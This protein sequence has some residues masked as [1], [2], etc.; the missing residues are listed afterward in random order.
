VADLLRRRVEERL[1]AAYLTH[2]MTYAG[3]DF[4]VNE[5]VLVPRSPI[6]ELIEN[7]FAPWVE[8]DAVTRVLDLCT[9]SGCIAIGCAYS[10]PQAQVD[11]VDISP[12]ALDV[13]VI[14]RERHGLND[15][16]HLVQSD[17]FAGLGQQRYNLIVSNPPY[18]SQAELAQ[19]PDEYHREPVL[20]LEAG[21]DGLDIVSRIL[22]QAADYLEPEGILVIEVGNSEAS[23]SR[24]YP[25]VPFLWLDFDHGGHGVF[26][27]T[28]QQ[29]IEYQDE[30]KEV[31]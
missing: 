31:E 3:L 5:H 9:G 7:H 11:A 12:Q 2:Q 21:H 28:A 18:V 15:R 1:P 16:L 4:Y 19:L 6:A 17:L 14:N 13:A 8:A 24:R 22:R 26:L 29:L 20:G 27:L 30:F 23:L 25:K 10:F